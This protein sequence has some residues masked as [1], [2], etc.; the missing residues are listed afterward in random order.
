MIMFIHNTLLT[1][2]L[3]SL[4]FFLLKIFNDLENYECFE[5]KRKTTKSFFGVLFNTNSIL[6]AFIIIRNA[7]LY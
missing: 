2:V 4:T 6:K 7:N 1:I 5:L 3:Y